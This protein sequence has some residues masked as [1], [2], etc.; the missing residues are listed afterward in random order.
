LKDWRGRPLI[1][2]ETEQGVD[3]ETLIDVPCQLL[4]AHSE[5]EGKTYANIT[6]IPHDDDKTALWPSGRYVRAKYLVEKSAAPAQSTTREPA[7]DDDPGPG[8]EP[9][10]DGY[11]EEDGYYAEPVF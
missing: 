7:E 4:V 2:E 5:R 11:P 8:D 3:L 6:A 9:P 1:R 10:G